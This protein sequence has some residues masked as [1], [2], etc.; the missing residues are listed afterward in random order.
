M[1]AIVPIRGEIRQLDRRAE[2]DEQVQADDIAEAPRLV[3]LLM[4]ILRDLAALKRRWWPQFIDFEDITVLGDGTT[5]Y[6][7]PH[8][9]GTRVRYWP[10]DWVGAA[11]PCLRRHDATTEDTLV[12]TSTSAGVVT[13]R[14][15][16]SG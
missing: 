11:A 2:P 13:V 5:P 15:E 16:R 12:L 8:S 14:V 7:L 3:R 9:F 10:V 4:R 6:G 1:S